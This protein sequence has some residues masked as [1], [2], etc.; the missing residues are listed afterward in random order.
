MYSNFYLLLYLY[1]NNGACS[2]GWDIAENNIIFVNVEICDN[3]K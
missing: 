3:F 2:S 1:L